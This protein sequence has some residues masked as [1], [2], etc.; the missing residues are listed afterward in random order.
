MQTLLPLTRDAANRH[1]VP[2]EI[3]AALVKQES[4]FNPGARSRAGAMGL[5]QLMPGTAKELGVSDPFDPAQSLDGGARYLRIQKDRFG[6]WEKALAAYNAGPGNVEKYGGVPPFAETQNY[7]R[8][9]LGS[10]S[11]MQ[12]S[13][14][15]QAATAPSAAQLQPPAA[16]DLSVP[17]SSPFQELAAR[18]L[19]GFR[20]AGSP[21]S[22]IGSPQSTASSPQSR[23]DAELARRRAAEDMTKGGFESAGFGSAGFGGDSLAG[24]ANN[25]VPLRRGRMAGERLAKQEQDFSPLDLVAGLLQ[26]RRQEQ[27]AMATPATPA[28]SGQWMKLQGVTTGNTGGSTGPHLDVRWGDRSPIK[29]E[30]VA[31]ILRVG[32]KSLL[33]FPVTSPY[34]MRRHPIHGDQRLHAGFDLGTPRGLPIEVA[35]GVQVVRK[36]YDEGG[37]GWVKE[38]KATDGR[39]LQLLH[40]DPAN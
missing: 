24:G 23:I 7:V 6:S 37:G 18:L 11:S 8:K 14:G 12:M 13:A 19:Q 2:P 10:A 32:G 1:G 34:G 20:G 36:F 16:S 15:G 26:P 5:T 27:P 31:G 35:P 29:P 39:I 40:L 33:D 30:D 22:E 21:R 3:F 38:L 25:V 17:S 9:V 4:R 28:A